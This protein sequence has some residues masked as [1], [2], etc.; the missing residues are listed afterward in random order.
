MSLKFKLN[1][2]KVSSVLVFLLLFQPVFAQY[3]FNEVDKKIEKY[4]K[5]LGNNV[6]ALI[7]KDGKLI[8]D[9]HWGDMD[10][11]TIAPIASCSK[12]LTAAVVMTLV[13]EGKISLDDK[14]AKYIPDFAKY[15]KGYITIRHCLSHQTGIEQEQTNLMS[16]LSR[17]KYNTLE[18]EVNDIM[19]K[20]D[21]AFNAGTGFAYGGVGLNIAGRIC[22]IVTKKNFNQLML[23][24]LFRPLGM[25]GTTFQNENFNLAPNPSGGAK[26]NAEEYMNFLIMILNKGMFNGKRILSEAAI[27]EMQ[28]EQITL[29][30]VKYT[31]AAGKGYTYGLGEWIMEKDAAGNSTVVACPGLFGTWPM[32]D[33]CRGYASIFFVKTLLGGER[34]RDAYLDIKTSIDAVIPS[35]CKN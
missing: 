12:W 8:Y 10:K 13:D 25:R 32:V 17:K 27:N 23:E 30:M 24:R 2:I 14:V 21:I 28:K 5:E 20:K 7:Y 16:I 22:E 6:I 26:S 31:P 3:D 11:K 1:C 35:N 9:K 15:S 33:K 29:D 4:R 18:E 19:S 34:K